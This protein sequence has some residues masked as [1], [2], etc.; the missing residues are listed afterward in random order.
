MADTA[1][2]WMEVSALNDLDLNGLVLSNGT[3]QSTLASANCL[4]ADAGSL[5]VFGRNADPS[6]NG[7]LPTLAGLFS[8]DLVNGGGSLELL[9][10]DGGVLDLVTYAS[11]TAGASFYVDGSKCDPVQNDMPANICVTPS[12]TTYGMSPDGGPGDRGT[13]GLVNGTC[14]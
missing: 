4:K 1:G 11:A 10:G 6:L 7:G 12:G 5:L 14:P 3:T 8:F 13:P 2:E 9:S